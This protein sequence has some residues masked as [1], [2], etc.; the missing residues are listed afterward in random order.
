MTAT[1]YYTCPHC[2]HQWKPRVYPP[3]WCPNRKCGKPLSEDAKRK[4]NLTRQRCALSR[5][6]DTR[7]FEKLWNA[8][9]PTIELSQKFNVSTLYIHYAAKALN[10]RRRPRGHGLRLY[11]K[12][13]A[14]ESE[15]RVFEFLRKHGGYCELKKLCSVVPADAIERLLYKRRIFKIAFELGRSQGRYKRNVKRFI[16]KKSVMRKGG[17]KTFICDSRT[18]VVR[19]MNRYLKK[20]KNS[21]IQRVLTSF[22]RQYLSEAERCAV[23]WHLGVRKFDASQIKRSIKI[24]GIIGPSRPRTGTLFPKKYNYSG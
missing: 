14:E 21:H 22:L 8:G 6:K 5:I 4:S 12:K 24:D 7:T 2:S 10:L 19:V 15:R 9:V 11:C 17:F 3:N 13:K 16:F 20:P 18:S 23:L 1:K